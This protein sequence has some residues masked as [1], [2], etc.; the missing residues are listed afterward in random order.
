MPQSTAVVR[1]WRKADQYRIFS[2]L[3][4]ETPYTAQVAVCTD[5]KMHSTGF[6]L[7]ALVWT[8]AW[9]CRW[10]LRAWRQE[11]PSLHPACHCHCGVVTWVQ[12]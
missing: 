9:T 6:S 8:P 5:A 11:Q 1:T 2:R 10:N 3:S 7:K 4:L 12:A